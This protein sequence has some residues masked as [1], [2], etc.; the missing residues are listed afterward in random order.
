MAFVQTLHVN[1]IGSQNRV[2]PIRAPNGNHYCLQSPDDAGQDAAMWSSNNGNA[3][4]SEKNSIN[5]PSTTN[6]S[7]NHIGNFW[8]V[9]DGTVIH[10][11]TVSIDGD[12]SQNFYH[13]FETV[14]DTWGI[15]DEPIVTVSRTGVLSGAQTPICIAK[16]GDGTIVC[17]FSAESEKIKGTHYSRVDYIIRSSGGVWGVS[18][19]L[20]TGGQIHWEQQRS[21]LGD[22]N[23]VHL[24][25]SGDGL[26]HRSLSITDVLDAEEEIASV[27]EYEFSNESVFSD[28]RLTTYWQENITLNIAASEIVNNGSPSP[29][30]AI[31]A[32]EM[33]LV[34]TEQAN[35][36]AVFESTVYAAWIDDASRQIYYSENENGAGWS[37]PVVAVSGIT[38]EGVNINVYRIDDNTKVM[39]VVYK[40]ETPTTLYTE[41]ILSPIETG[42]TGGRVKLSIEHNIMVTL[43]I[44]GGGDE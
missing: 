32:N 29:I 33:W 43:S 20:D 3:A 38:G 8:T 7:D 28:S 19:P 9:L 23:R 42:I 44:T 13:T 21:I 10:I 5:R 24:L 36:M 18:E 37:V 16:R 11:A 1:P 41:I 30:E 26:K 2:G 27:F 25:W 14:T 31:T 22:S 40:D 15:T 34:F 6:D 35:S 39:G 17:V 12:D 4:W